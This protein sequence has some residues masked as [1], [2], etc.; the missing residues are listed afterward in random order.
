MKRKETIPVT[1]ARTVTFGLA[2][3]GALST[4]VTAGTMSASGKS[5]TI[6]MYSQNNSGENGTVKLTDIAGGVKVVVTLTG[7]PNALSQPTYI[8]L[9][10]CKNIDKV[11]Q[12]ML[13]NTLNG[14]SVSVLKGVHLARLT[15][16]KYAINVHY[17]AEDLGAYASCGNI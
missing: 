12:Y 8:H 3:I 17:S 6:K 11:P 7:T 2:F 4:S 1:L 5:L 16:G 13:T 9:G 10:T 14:Q 15:G